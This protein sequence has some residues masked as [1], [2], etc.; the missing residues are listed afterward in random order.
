MSRL[1]V[2]T[3]EPQIK[4]IQ[5]RLSRQGITTFK[6]SDISYVLFTTY[7][8]GDVEKAYELLILLEDS[9]EGIIRP[10][11]SKIKLLGAVNREGVTCYLDAL[12]F[13]MFARL[14]SFEAMLYKNFEDA[15][16]KR[17]ATLLRLWVNALRAGKLIT[18]DITKQI[19]LQLASCGW[20]DAAELCQQDAS[21]AFTF[22]TE[23]LALPLLTLKMDIF[24]TGKED[25][26][27]D[28]KFINERLLEL[29]IPEERKDGH[30][31]TLEDCLEMFFNNKI[32]VK[33]YLE[34]LERRNTLTSARSRASVSSTKANAS[35]VEVVEVGDLIPSSPMRRS[36]VGSN[37]SSPT[38]PTLQRRRAPSII[39]EHY[40]NEK[41]G[42]LE[43]V[44][45]GNESH[46]RTRKEVMMPAWQFF[47]LIRKLSK[48]MEQDEV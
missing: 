17:L 34:S 42:L 11:E 4:T 26:N 6:P 23:T 15:P 21:E 18:V 27:D 14:A 44:G 19:Q 20:K 24:H 43:E 33:R 9:E 36:Q 29:A 39:Q 10:Y 45:E 2:L 1:D 8:R 5:Q 35:H 40:I 28:H 46:P 37:P 13:A 12:L 32:E 31:I 30:A 25:T 47:S 41:H 22:I 16:R 38:T 3:T 7:A 48:S